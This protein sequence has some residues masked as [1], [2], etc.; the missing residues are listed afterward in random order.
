MEGV[1]ASA[2]WTMSKLLQF[3]RDIGLAPV[4]PWGTMNRMCSDHFIMMAKKLAPVIWISAQI[5][6]A[7]SLTKMR[8]LTQTGPLLPRGSE[9]LK[10]DG[11]F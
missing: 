10:R 7:F 2:R 8:S 4:K 1:S 6:Q 3:Q 9:A 5:W 11:V